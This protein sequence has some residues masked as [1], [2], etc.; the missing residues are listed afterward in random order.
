MKKY[1]ISKSKSKFGVQNKLTNEVILPCD[2]DFVEM[3]CDSYFYLSKDRRKFVLNEKG[4]LVFDLKNKPNKNQFSN[5]YGTFQ[6]LC[7][8]E[9][10]NLFL[11]YFGENTNK[12]T[13]INEQVYQVVIYRNTVAKRLMSKEAYLNE[14]NTSTGFKVGMEEL[15]DLIS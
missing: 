13:A 6:L 14:M 8:E 5:D 1:K 4:D 9:K 10:E 15:K 7:I 11:S 12:D 3:Y 2:Y